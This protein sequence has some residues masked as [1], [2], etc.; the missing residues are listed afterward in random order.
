MG[1]NGLNLVTDP[2]LGQL[3]PEAIS[4]KLPWGATTW[5]D[6]RTE[7]KRDLRIWLERDFADIPGVCDRVLDRWAFTYA[8]G[9]TGGTYTDRT[10]PIGEFTEN[11]VPLA[12]IFATP[13]ADR[14]YLA[15]EWEFEGL[16]VSMLEQLNANAATLTAKYWNGKAWT[17]FGTVQDGTL[18]S[19]ATL[20]QS[21]RITW[22]LPSDWER[23]RLNG[24]AD[25]YYWI[26]LSVNAALSPS[27]AAGQ[28]MAVHAPAGLKR[29]AQYLALQKILK[30]LAAQSGAPEEW[31]KRA[32][33]YGADA[34]ALY[35]SLLEKGGIPLDINKSQ[36]I[37]RGE[38]SAAISP[39][40]LR[41]G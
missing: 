33:D 40:H 38:P 14:L 34:Q 37:D 1:W 15:G 2:E 28:L 23:R 8:W 5:P 13:A 39:T 16:F 21:G 25:F 17:A 20:A 22:V 3:E 31:L 10:S 4:P 29:V 9:L 18:V 41:R 27:T 36:S 6:A 35:T 30:G 12:S 7:A 24:T 19:N 26:E 32:E 11:D